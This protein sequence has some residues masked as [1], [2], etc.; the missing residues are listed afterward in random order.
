MA[1]PVSYDIRDLIGAPNMTGII[2]QR[3]SGLPPVYTDQ[4]YKT[5]AEWEVSGDY[6]NYTIFTGQQQVATLSVDGGPS[7]QVQLRTLG[8]RSVKLMTSTEN[9][10]IPANVLENLLAYDSVAKQEKGIQ[11]VERQVGELKKRFM[12]LRTAAW[13][14][15]LAYNSVNFDAAGNL[16]N[17]TAA[18]PGNGTQITFGI[19]NG[20]STTAGQPNIPIPDT[21]TYGTNIS[22]STATGLDP[23]GTGAVIGVPVGDW[24]S[25][26]TDIVTQIRKLMQLAVQLTGYELKHAWYGVNIPTWLVRNGTTEPYLARNPVK[27]GEFISTNELPDMLGLTWHPAYQ[28]YFY[29]QNNVRQQ[30]I[31]QNTVIFTPEPS[32][33]W[34]GML[35]GTKFIPTEDS[36][37]RTFPG[38]ETVT[39]GLT[40][41][42][43]MYCY[44]KIMDDPAK[45]KVIAGDTFL[46]ALPNPLCVFSAP[47]STAA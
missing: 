10:Q 15:A 36:L 28:G 42:A 25:P 22:T 31:Q 47:M 43:G 14:S 39:T 13:S 29:D 18:V 4:F 27:N 9:I 37:G 2:W 5:P 26:A 20:S 11:E 35:Q 23:F 19:P 24:S 32:P 33:E 8:N 16:L 30:I 6:G 7:K 12:N 17:P 41:V 1:S 45:I 38:G 44:G 34:V 21:A 3:K 40:E 46:P